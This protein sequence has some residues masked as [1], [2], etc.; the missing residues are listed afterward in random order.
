VKTIKVPGP[1]RR[2]VRIKKVKVRGRKGRRR[3]AMAG[4]GGV[5][6]KLADTVALQSISSLGEGKKRKSRRRKARRLR[7]VSKKAAAPRR[8]RRRG[9]RRV[10]RVSRKAAHRRR[11]RR[12]GRRM[13]GLG[14]SLGSLGRMGAHLADAEVS[15]SWP[16]L[17][18]L[19]YAITMPGLEALGGVTLGGFLY[20]VVQ[21]GLFGKL[22]MKGKQLEVLPQIGTGLIS[23]IAMWELGRLVGSGN[24]AKFGAFYALGKM[25]DTLVMKPYVVNK[26]FAL[27]GWGLG[28]MRVGDETE[29]RGLPT[30][31]QARVSDDTEL[32][33]ELGQRV[34]T[35]EE[36]LGEASD[37][38]ASEEDSALF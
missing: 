15:A 18:P 9:H 26:I 29:L 33:G 34:V 38:G 4:F 16:V 10:R 13:S 17:G 31:G 7:R 1:V 14:S 5:L 6:S 25:I 2:I 27:S 24:L 37:E 22:L 20:G 30:L 19:Q 32:R 11:R 3:S 35:E 28:T 21:E 12:G 8:R 23:S 36:L